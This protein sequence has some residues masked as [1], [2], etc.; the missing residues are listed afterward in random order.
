MTDEMTKE[1]Y[2]ARI[3]EL[4]NQLKE[5]DKIDWEKDHRKKIDE[6]YKEMIMKVNE[7][8]EP[9]GIRFEVKY[10]N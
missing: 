2:E 4:E 8:V 9:F 7:E 5:A 3:K 1:Q 6:T 10:K